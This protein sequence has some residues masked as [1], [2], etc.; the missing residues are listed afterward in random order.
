MLL[1]IIMLNSF[2]NLM[3]FLMM[4]LLNVLKKLLQILTKSMCFVK[5]IHAGKW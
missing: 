4:L 1:L 5:I 3:E 2:V